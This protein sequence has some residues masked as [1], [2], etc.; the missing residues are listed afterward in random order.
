MASVS[1]RLVFSLSHFVSKYN[2]I[3]MEQF[4]SILHKVRSS[5][6]NMLGTIILLQ[7][8]KLNFKEINPF[9]KPSLSASVKESAYLYQLPL[10]EHLCCGLVCMFTSKDINYNS[11]TTGTIMCRKLIKLRNECHH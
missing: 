3:F 6:L 4:V 7:L 10:Q 8:I 2:R 11:Q 5:L 1:R 9:I